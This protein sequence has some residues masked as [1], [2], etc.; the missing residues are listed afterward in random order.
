MRDGRQRGETYTSNH[1]SGVGGVKVII[2]KTEGGGTVLKRER[3]VFRQVLVLLER[4]HV[5]SLHSIR[6]TVG[7]R[8]LDQ[9]ELIK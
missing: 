3:I 8:G 2:G 4:S 7:M 1:Q 5:N 6:R 9:E